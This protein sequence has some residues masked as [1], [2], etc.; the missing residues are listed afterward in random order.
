MQARIENIFRVTEATFWDVLFFEHEYNARLHK[1]LGFDTYEVRAIEDL[2]DGKVRRLLR[3]EPPLKVP[4]M[5]RKKLQSRLYYEEEGVY[6]RLARRWEFSSNTSVARDSTKISGVITTR[7]HP[8]GTLHVVELD[9]RI[10]ALGL[11]SMIEKLVEKNVR[12]SYAVTTRFTN[13]YAAEKGL[14]LRAVGA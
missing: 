8:E 3:A 1:E 12:E 10:T 2:G 11:G 13:A 6:D 7:P 9:V 5:L 14:Q 4:E